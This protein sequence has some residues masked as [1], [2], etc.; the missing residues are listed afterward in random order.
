MNCRTEEELVRLGQAAH[1]LYRDMAKSIDKAL[2]KMEKR[3]PESD[4]GEVTI[5]AM[6]MLVTSIMG[7][8]TNEFAKLICEM[9]VWRKAYAEMKRQ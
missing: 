4:Q 8:S 1:S 6:G 5:Q 7:P 3:V 9:A 2:S